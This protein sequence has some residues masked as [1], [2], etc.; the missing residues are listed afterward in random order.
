M[1]VGLH[2]HNSCGCFN[3]P[4][5]P[6][7]WHDRQAASLAGCGGIKG[8][9]TMCKNAL[10]LTDH[11]AVGGSSSF[12]QAAPA[13]AAVAAGESPFLRCITL[14]KDDVLTRYLLPKLVEQGSA[15]AVALTCSRLR[16]LCQ[17][18]TLH[19]NL[20]KELE[21][22][23]SPWRRPVLAERLVEAFPNCTS[24]ACALDSSGLEDVYLSIRI[25]LSG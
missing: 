23:D 12:V 2:R 15:A 14:L 24:L 10:S 25:M 18:S 22:A 1:V 16:R 6:R 21:G 5:L 3:L 17:H 7:R 11:A 19:L 4:P 8:R 9:W 13:D 20:A